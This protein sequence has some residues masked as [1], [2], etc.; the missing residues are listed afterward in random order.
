[1]MRGMG[2]GR[3]ALHALCTPKLRA[4]MTGKEAISFFLMV[5]IQVTLIF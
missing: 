3:L 1:M 5:F 4:V 2:A